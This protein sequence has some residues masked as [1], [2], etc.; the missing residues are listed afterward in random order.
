MHIA[1]Q[2]IFHVCALPWFASKEACRFAK[3]KSHIL[4]LNKHQKREL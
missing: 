4:R 2:I 3:T 1:Q